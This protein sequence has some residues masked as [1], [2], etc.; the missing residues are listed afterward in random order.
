MSE[1]RLFVCVDSSPGALAAA[2]L[3]LVLAQEHGGK[4]RA[5]SVVEDSHTARRLDMGRRHAEPAAERLERGARTMLDRIA[6]MAAEHGIP[7]ETE[8]RAGEVLSELMEGARQ[9][10][11]DFILIGRSGRSGPGSPML[12]SLAMHVIEFSDWP[13]IVVPAEPEG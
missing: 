6:A 3:A 7:I 11:P 12:G 10:G 2:K 9:W 4:L 8:M 13:V 5:V 1:L